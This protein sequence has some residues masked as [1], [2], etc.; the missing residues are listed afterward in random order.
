MTGLILTH[1]A[2]PAAKRALAATTTGLS[3]NLAEHSVPLQA[4]PGG[5]AATWSAEQGRAGEAYYGASQRYAPAIANGMLISAQTLGTEGYFAGYSVDTGELV[6]YN[7]PEPPAGD[8]F[9][10]FLVAAGLERVTE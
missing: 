1:T 4:I 6:A 2:V 10:A 3:G 8:T 7:T 9:D 5:P